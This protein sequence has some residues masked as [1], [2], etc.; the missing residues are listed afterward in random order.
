MQGGVKMLG[1]S[2]DGSYIVG[3]SD[4]GNGLDIVSPTNPPPNDNPLCD[5]RICLLNQG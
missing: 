1:F 5:V 2:W 4:E 3:G